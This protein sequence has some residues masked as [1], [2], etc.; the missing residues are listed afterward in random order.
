[1]AE[2]ATKRATYADLEA[3]HPHLVAEIVHGAL[4]T[5]PR[6]SPR[7]A[8]TASSR[9]TEIA[10]PYQ[11]GRGGPGGWVFMTEPELHSGE[12]V[13]VPDI[14][15][16]RRERLPQLPD[17]PYLTTP[18]DWL[19]EVIY[20]STEFYDRG[21]KRDI[22]AAAG[23]SYLWLVDPASQ[24][25]EAFQLAAGQ[26]LLQATMTGDQEVKLP[27]FDAAPFNLGLLWPYD[28]PINPN[29]P[30]QA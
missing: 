7:H 25:L 15:G 21:P 23:V 28:K 6:P 17:T 3:V 10:G 30:P 14:A 27:P 16:W 12:D 4:V 11:R 26:W 8:I 5:H 18:P 9:V 2:T 24:Q 1:M 29:D 20:P 22:Y 19:C 13:V